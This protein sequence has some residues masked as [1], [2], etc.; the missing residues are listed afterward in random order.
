MLQLVFKNE[1]GEYTI[2]SL[3]AFMCV[4]YLWEINKLLVI[5]VA[6]KEEKGVGMW[7]L[8]GQGNFFQKTSEYIYNVEPCQCIIY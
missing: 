3:S 5:F 4:W 1:E 2:K 8:E 6:N 7:C